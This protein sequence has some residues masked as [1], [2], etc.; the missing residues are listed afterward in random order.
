MEAVAAGSADEAKKMKILCLHGFRTSG[1]FLKK[2]IGRWD[3]SILSH[4][5]M[6][7]YTLIFGAIVCS[8][9]VILTVG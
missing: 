2:Q 7:L 5:D 3:P 9:T 8:F 1:A 6:V 4:F